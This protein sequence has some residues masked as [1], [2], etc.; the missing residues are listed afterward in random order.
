MPTRCLQLPFNPPNIIQQEFPPMRRLLPSP[1]AASLL[2][3]VRSR[4]APITA[5]VTTPVAAA[6]CLLASCSPTVSTAAASV[7]HSTTSPRDS[8]ARSVRRDR[9]QQA[10]VASRVEDYLAQYWCVVF[11]I[12]NADTGRGTG[13][14]VLEMERYLRW[15]GARFKTVPLQHHP[16]GTALLEQLR[17]HHARSEAQNPAGT[18]QRFDLP[19][20]FVNKMLVGTV[21]D[22]RDLE[23]RRQLKDIIHFGFKWK[24]GGNPSSRGA[25]SGVSEEVYRHLPLGVEKSRVDRVVADN[26]MLK[27][28]PSL[29]GDTSAFKARHRGTPVLR[30][31]QMLPQVSPSINVDTE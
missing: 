26:P 4:T 19:L 1:T 11:C 18:R 7:R 16:H 3:S 9:P 12:H 29:Y 24:T 17:I 15:Y 10:F 27:P 2:L 14:S 6:S 25:F 30:P 23:A 20:V 13:S 5:P 22:L 8:A 28:L 31:I 21:S